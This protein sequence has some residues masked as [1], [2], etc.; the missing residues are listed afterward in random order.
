MCQLADVTIGEDATLSKDTEK[1][2]GLL[3]STLISIGEGTTLST[4]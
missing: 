4:V 2:Q 1:T 3:V